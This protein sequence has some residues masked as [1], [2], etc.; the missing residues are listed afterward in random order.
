[1][2]KYDY[3]LAVG[4][5]WQQSADRVYNI[6]TLVKD[7]IIINGD[8]SQ[9]DATQTYEERMETDLLLLSTLFESIDPEFSKMPNEYYSQITG[10][11]KH[12]MT[13]YK[14]ADIKYDLLGKQG[15][16]SND[17]TIGNSHRN[18][19]RLRWLLTGICKL[20]E[21]VIDLKLGKNQI[22]TY[23]LLVL[24]DDFLLIINRNSLPVVKDNWNSLFAQKQFQKQG[25]GHWYKDSMDT[26]FIDFCSRDGIW[27]DDGT[28]RWLRKIKRFIQ[29]TPFTLAIKNKTNREDVIEH[30]I[31]KMAYIEGIGILRWAKHLPIFE[32]YARTLIRLGQSTPVEEIEAYLQ[33]RWDRRDV[34]VVTDY[35][36]EDYDLTLDMWEQQY[37]IPRDL[38]E[39]IE[40]NL[41]KCTSLHDQILSEELLSKFVFCDEYIKY[42]V[43]MNFESHYI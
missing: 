29:T 30:E 2:T 12:K 23:G 3:A 6:K 41:D 27:R 21:I 19:S 39:T 31:K 40:D 24:G 17:T 1:L 18:V 25:L 9:N 13:L 26:K 37:D 16:G 20:E 15:T 14:Y 7:S 36:V 8:L 10:E 4:Q 28:L 5:N 34:G 43:D 42:S 38:I 33:S 11:S 32:K 35:R 22:G